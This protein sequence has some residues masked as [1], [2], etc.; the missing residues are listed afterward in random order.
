M[1]SSSEL[2]SA[3][4]GAGTAYWIL[5]LQGLGNLFPWNTLITAAHYFR[6]RFCGA[7]YETGFEN[8][9]SVVTMLAQVCGL[10]LSLGY[11][12]KLPLKWCVLLP[13]ALSTAV[14]ALCTGLVAL[15][16][17]S[18]DVLFAVTLLACALFGMNSAVSGGGIFGL[19]GCLPAEYTA[20]VMCGQGLGG[21]VVSLTSISS[22]YFS[23]APVE[24]FCPGLAKEEDVDMGVWSESG[25][26]VCEVTVDHSALFFFAACCVVLLLCFV[27]FFA[28]LVL[29]FTM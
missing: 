2:A 26:Q 13:L 23:P 20:A 10:V 22:M 8:Y 21:V 3:G 15:T 9:F 11:L 7:A 6:M 14:M 5:F 25:E 16:G 4:A 19:S 27:T 24:S 29:P 12:E 28:L 1:D 18:Q 17:L